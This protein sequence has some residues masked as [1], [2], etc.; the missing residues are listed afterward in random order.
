MTVPTIG[1]ATA[2]VV[3]PA[4]TGSG[5]DVASAAAVKSQSAQP[6]QP[7]PADVQKALQAIKVKVESASAANLR[8]SID[9]SSGDVVA[10]IT[11]GQTGELIRQIPS[12][13]ALALAKDIDQLKGLLLRQRA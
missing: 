11:D 5:R 2:P 10:R 4:Q 8:F 3:Q 12:E 9:D 13:E 6:Q 1:S 7:S